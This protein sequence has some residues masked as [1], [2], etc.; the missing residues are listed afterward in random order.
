ML[1]SPTQRILAII[2]FTEGVFC[3][4][5]ASTFGLTPDLVQGLESISKI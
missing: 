4:D 5:P 3:S 1:D 2:C